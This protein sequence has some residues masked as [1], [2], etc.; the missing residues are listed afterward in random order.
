MKLNLNLATSP[1]ENNRR[2]IVGVGLAG[3]AALIAL[4]ILSHQTYS[5][6]RANRAIRSDISR[7]ENEIQVE[8]AKEQ[9]L[10]RFFDLSDSKKVLD[11]SN[12][13]NSLIEARTFPWPKIFEDLEKTLP[14]GVRIISIAPRLEGGRALIKLTIGAVDDQ[15]EVEFL[16]NLAQSKVFSGIRVSDEKYNDKPEAKGPGGD[17][18]V[19]ALEAWYSTI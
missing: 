19:I 16:H 14:P 10:A 2:F 1:L 17:H 6:W 5:T 4:F 8:T 9:D 3:I 15:A 7:I 18:I 12:F 11:R 13:L